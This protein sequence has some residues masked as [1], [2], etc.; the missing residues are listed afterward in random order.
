MPT[1]LETTTSRIGTHTLT[2]GPKKGETIV[3]CAMGLKEFASGRSQCLR[4]YKKERVESA[5]ETMELFP[6]EEQR[7][8]R[9]QKASEID[10]INYEDLPQKSMKLPKVVDGKQVK[11]EDGKL[12][13]SDQSVE[14]GIWWMS[15]HPEGMLFS[16]WLSMVKHPS[17]QNLTIGQISDM[18]TESPE[19]LEE[20]TQIAG[21]LSESKL[22]VGNGEAPLEAGKKTRRRRR[23]R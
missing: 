2:S 9:E 14:Y 11:D 5:K 1:G 20:V 7:A 21:E 4:D 23:R 6:E 15:D 8:Y 10:S 19:D 12:V 16:A 3:I 13:F 22:T 17:Q 18:F